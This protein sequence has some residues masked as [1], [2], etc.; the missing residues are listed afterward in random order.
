MRFRIGIFLVLC[1]CAPGCLAR[2]VARDQTLFVVSCEKPC[3]PVHICRQCGKKWYWVPVEAG[4]EFLQL[5]LRTSILP[6][7]AAPTVFWDTTIAG[8][9][10]RLNAQ[11][12]YMSSNH[13]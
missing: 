12:Q 8:M 5:V 1:T 7:S 3:G 13:W 10:K 6:P 2:Q 4:P 11:G 9:A